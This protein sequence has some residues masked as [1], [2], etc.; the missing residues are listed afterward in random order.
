MSSIQVASDTHGWEKWANIPKEKE[1]LLKL[2][3]KTGTQNAVLLSGDR[4]VAGI[5]K[6]KESTKRRPLYEITSSSLNRPTFTSD[7]W[8]SQLTHPSLI[9]DNNF[10]L[11]TIDW[12]KRKVLLSIEKMNGKTVAQQTVFF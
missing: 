11:L 8:D 4:H 5:Y 12:K 9:F 3:K 6:F 1:R 7:E 10:G 2:L